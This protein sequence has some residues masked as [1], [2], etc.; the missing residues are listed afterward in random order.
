MGGVFLFMAGGDCA[1]V[2]LFLSAE[3]SVKHFQNIR[4]FRDFALCRWLSY[5]CFAG[6]VSCVCVCLCVSACY[7]V[8]C[9]CLLVV[10]TSS[11]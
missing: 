7:S 8:L 4:F 11:G 5:D 6:L 2:C 10:R 3:A 9:V 1:R